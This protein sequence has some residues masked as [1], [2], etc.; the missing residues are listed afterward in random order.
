MTVRDVKPFVALG[1]VPYFMDRKLIQAL[2]SSDRLS[3]KMAIKRL[4]KLWKEA[5]GHG[6]S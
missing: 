2:M 5:P 3:R 1:V 6:N 4:Y